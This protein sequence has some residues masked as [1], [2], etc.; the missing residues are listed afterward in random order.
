MSRTL[1]IAHRGASSLAPE[2]TMAAFKK[3]VDLGAD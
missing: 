2:N 1:N 3:A